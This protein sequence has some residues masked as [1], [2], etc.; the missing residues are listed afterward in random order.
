MP[1]RIPGGEIELSITE[2][3]R[4]VLAR[5]GFRVIEEIDL[6]KWIGATIEGQ[7]LVPSTIAIRAALEPTRKLVV[8]AHESGHLIDYGQNPKEGLLYGNKI[9]KNEAKAWVNGRLIAVKF[10]I[11]EEYLDYWKI[12]LDMRR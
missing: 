6:G 2:A 7:A 12:H 11:Y 4:L 1:K 10:G 3:K 5:Y 9:K 8:I